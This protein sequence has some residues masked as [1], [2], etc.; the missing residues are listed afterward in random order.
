[1]LRDGSGVG[2]LDLPKIGFGTSRL[3][4]DECVRAVSNALS[5]G[6]RLI[7]TAQAYDNEQDIGAALSGSRVLREEIFL[8]TKVHLRDMAPERVRLRTEDS[9]RHLRT[10]YID[11]LLVHWPSKDVPL[12]ATLGAFRRL[13]DESKVHHIGVANFPSSLLRVALALEPAICCNQIE[14]H[15]FLSQTA[16]LNVARTSGLHLIAYSATAKGNAAANPT[17]QRIGQKYGKTATQV[18]IRWLVQQVG[19]SALLK[20]TSAAHL[21]ENMEALHF[22][23]DEFDMAQI[24]SLHC[25]LRLVNRPW[26]PQWDTC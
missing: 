5:V 15:A 3:K 26:A 24:S 4:G 12:E 22:T 20:T 23:L 6:Y 1:M 8:V 13:R 17:L 19:V 9:L 14:Y 11:L 25:G 18:S 16:I 2:V 7:D 10:D 21:Q